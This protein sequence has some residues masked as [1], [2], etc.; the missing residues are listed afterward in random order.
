MRAR[1][2]LSPVIFIIQAQLSREGYLF[3]SYR[4]RKRSSSPRTLLA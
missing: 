4:R 1:F 3:L 2:T